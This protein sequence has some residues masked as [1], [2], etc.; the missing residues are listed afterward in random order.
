VILPGRLTRLTILD[1]GL[2]EVRGGERLIGIPAY[3]LETDRGARILFDTGF[4]PAYATDPGIADRDGLPRFG[5]LLDFGPRQ[6]ADRRAGRPWLVPR[7]TSISSSSA[8]AISTTSAR[9]TFS[10]TRPIVMTAIER[11]DPAPS[12]FGYVRPLPG[13]R[14]AIT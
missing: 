4:P 6:T 2:F 14:R 1:L 7:R 13:P 5:R 9:C 12:Y 10:P 3:L 8:T 11:A